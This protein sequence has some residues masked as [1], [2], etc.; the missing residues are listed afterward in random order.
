VKQEIAL[1]DKRKCLRAK[2]SGKFNDIIS[3]DENK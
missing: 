1:K 3:G 2:I